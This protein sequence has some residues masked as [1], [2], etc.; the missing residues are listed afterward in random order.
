[1]T[2]VLVT[3]LDNVFNFHRADAKCQYVARLG[4]P[5]SRENNIVNAF[6]Q[7]FIAL[8]NDF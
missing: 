7:V 6:C 4:R 8:H 5:L 3:L 2:M 1:M